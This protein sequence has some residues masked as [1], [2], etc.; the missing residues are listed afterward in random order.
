MLSLES[1]LASREGEG[2]DDDGNQEG[3]PVWCHGSAMLPGFWEVL[4]VHQPW[5]VTMFDRLVKTQKPWRYVHFSASSSLPHVEGARLAGVL[6]PLNP[7]AAAQ[8]SP[9]A[10][11]DDP[12]RDAVGTLMEVVASETTADRR[13]FLA[14]RALGPVKLVRVVQ[15]SPHIRAEVEWRPDWEETRFY[16][17][18]APAARASEV[19]AVHHE[20]SPRDGELKRLAPLS[21]NMVRVARDFHEIAPPSGNPES[22]QEMAT[23]AARSV[24]TPSQRA[25]AEEAAEDELEQGRL[26]GMAGQ[27]WAVIRAVEQLQASITKQGGMPPSDVKAGSGTPPS[28]ARAMRPLVP[29]PQVASALKPLLQDD[30]PEWN[31]GRRARWLSYAMASMLP[32]LGRGPGRQALLEA[33]STEE[34]LALGLRVLNARQST[35]AALLV[36]QSVQKTS[37]ETDAVGSAGREDAERGEREKGLSIQEAARLERMMGKNSSQFSRLDT[38]N[39]AWKQQQKEE[40]RK[41]MLWLQQRAI[42]EAAECTLRNDGDDQACEAEWQKVKDLSEEADEG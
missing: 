42:Q 39:G 15:S 5:L 26:E 32:E 20:V 1:A 29:A 6:A 34:R 23:Q 9:I 11:D 13:L 37:D 2:D 10:P 40:R 12:Q 33:P 7:A 41:S 18:D 14:V 21:E 27:I 36:M 22:V 17:G 8:A 16:G 19:W 24:S 38:S 30:H 25:A 31:A 28:L 35:L 3:L 4:G